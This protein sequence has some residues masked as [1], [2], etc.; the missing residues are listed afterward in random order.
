MDETTQKLY[1]TVRLEHPVARFLH[2]KDFLTQAYS[3]LKDNQPSFSYLKFAA[4]MGFGERN[5]FLRLVI[6][7]QR[8]LTTKSADRIADAFNFSS[9]ERK[10][11]LTMVK[12]CNAK[13]GSE[14]DPLLKK[15]AHLK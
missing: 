8:T 3:Y 14:R 6:N 5:N 11:W 15:L 7:G 12:Y 4:D 2:Y 9:T 13:R 10:Y 1:R